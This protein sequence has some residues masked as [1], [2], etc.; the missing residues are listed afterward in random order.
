MNQR[1]TA[2]AADAP[3]TSRSFIP[4]TKSTDPAL[5]ALW[6]GAAGAQ[7]VT[8]GHLMNAEGGSVRGMNA[9][10]SGVDPRTR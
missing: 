8:L 2:G 6:T 3:G 10:Q 1:D 4:C 7:S 5:E 9:K